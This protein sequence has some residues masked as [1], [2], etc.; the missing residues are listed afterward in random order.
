[1]MLMVTAKRGGAAGLE[2]RCLRVIV[3]PPNEFPHARQGPAW[4]EMII[5]HMHMTPAPVLAVAVSHRLHAPPLTSAPRISCARQ[6]RQGD[7]HDDPP[8]AH[9]A[10][11]PDS[12]RRDS[13]PRSPS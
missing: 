1:M 13:A 11:R 2:R 7:A 10:Q 6:A 12:Y 4:P 8:L 3:S 9:R 5:V